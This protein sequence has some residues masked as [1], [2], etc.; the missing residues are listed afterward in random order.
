MVLVTYIV[1]GELELMVVIASGNLEIDFHLLSSFSY[2]FLVAQA[3][4][5]HYWLDGT[6]SK[7]IIREETL[8][9]AKGIHYRQTCNH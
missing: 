9:F 1:W 8:S 5:E 7:L 2:P 4:V 6:I 3:K